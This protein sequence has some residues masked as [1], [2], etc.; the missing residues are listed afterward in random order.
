MNALIESLCSE[1]GAILPG[2]FMMRTLTSSIR[3]PS[4]TK[5]TIFSLLILLA[6]VHTALSIPYLPNNILAFAGAAM[7]FYINRDYITGSIVEWYIIAVLSITTLSVVS[8]VL[9]EGDYIPF[10]SRGLT[11][12]YNIT[13]GLAVFI[14][15]VHIGVRQSRVLFRAIALFLIIG[16]TLEL[17]GPMKP[18]SDWFRNATLSSGFYDLDG[19]DLEMYGGL[20]RPKFFASEPSI[21]GVSI[22]ISLFMWG[23]CFRKG[24][25]FDRVVYLLAASAGFYAVRSPSIIMGLI[26]VFIF[27]CIP[28]PKG[29]GFQRIYSVIPL[30]YAAIAAVFPVIIKYTIDERVVGFEYINTNSFYARMIS[31]FLIAVA[32]V[33]NKP[34]F[35]LGLANDRGLIDYGVKIYYSA[36]RLEYVPDYLYETLGPNAANA[37]WFIFISFGLVGAIVLWFLMSFLLKR[38]RVSTS[39]IYIV[40][41]ICFTFWYSFG[42]VN[43]PLAWVSFMMAAGLCRIHESVSAPEC[44]DAKRS[45]PGVIAVSSNIK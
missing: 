17:L 39:M 44:Q 19:R 11:F 31:P 34:W 40:C 6:G 7:I 5:R 20:V 38:L 26:S 10:I 27:Y 24:N 14:A 36:G 45:R 43:S 13:I 4:P 35:G 12:I 37:F 16:A 9:N 23:C 29:G 42:R 15:I 1:S 8:C 22:G 33:D 2:S 21:L 18:V 25:L 3:T 41:T 30:V 28:Y 32:V